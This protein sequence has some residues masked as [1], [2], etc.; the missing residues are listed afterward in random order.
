[1]PLSQIFLRYDGVGNVDFID[2]DIDIDID[3]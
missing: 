2:I 3:F 1:M